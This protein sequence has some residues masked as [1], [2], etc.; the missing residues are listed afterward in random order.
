MPCESRRIENPPSLSDRARSARSIWQRPRALQRAN[1]M[2]LARIRQLAA[3]ET[4]H[5]LGLMHNYAGSIVNRSSVMD[6]PPPT[7][8]LGADGA[9]DVSDAYAIGIGEWDKVSIA[10]GYSDLSQAKNET[11]ALDKILDAALSRGLL[12]LTD[13]DAARSLRQPIAHLWDTGSNDLDGLRRVMAV[14][15]VALRNLSEKRFRTYVDAVL[16]MCSLRCISTTAI[17]WLR[18]E[19]DRRTRLLLQ[20]SR[21]QG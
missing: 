14:R 20:S 6:Y 17:K 13:Q 4:G 1:E 21:E 7:V 16:E 9:L 2:A 19:V 10:Y 12:Y 8:A 15:A 3:H 11:L 18:C 5:T